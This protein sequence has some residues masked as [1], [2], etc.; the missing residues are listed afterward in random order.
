MDISQNIQVMHDDNT[1]LN[2]ESSVEI[3]P[4]RWSSEMS[5]DYYMYEIHINYFII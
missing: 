5:F 2:S 1:S 4:L 3:K